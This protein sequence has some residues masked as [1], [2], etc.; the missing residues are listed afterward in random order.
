[1]NQYTV[2]YCVEC[3]LTS[4]LLNGL[5]HDC[6]VT[7]VSR[8]EE[9]LKALETG[10]QD[11]GCLICKPTGQGTNGGCRCSPSKLRYRMQRMQ[12][13]LNSL[14]SRCELQRPNPPL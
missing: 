9:E 4:S 6:A 11:H 8:L 2:G 1:M 3:K 7:R 13:E 12:G 14:R 5:C 10:C